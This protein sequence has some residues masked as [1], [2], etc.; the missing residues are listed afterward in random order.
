MSGV[1]LTARADV[2]A[3]A[4]DDAAGEDRCASAAAAAPGAE[5]PPPP[6][7]REWE[8]RT[9][10]AA[11][12]AGSAP[13]AGDQRGVASPRA[14][15]S[16]RT[17]R[18][19]R[20]R[21]GAATPRRTA[22]RPTRRRGSCVGSSSFVRPRSDVGSRRLRSSHLLSLNL[23]QRGTAATTAAAPDAP[24][25]GVNG[26]VRPRPGLL[27]ATSRLRARLLFGLNLRER[28]DAR[29]AT[30]GFRGRAAPRRFSGR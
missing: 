7:R 17:H 29:V 21:G 26:R 15:A 2:A 6:S 5:P 13:G 24:H 30:R 22:Y 16:P 1:R 3:E 20:R 12:A 25:D 14:G 23:S 10:A 11:A 19:R 18:R 8:T 9:S 28:L 27:L 4:P